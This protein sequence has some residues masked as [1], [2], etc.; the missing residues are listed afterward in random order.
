MCRVGT[1]RNTLGYLNG[2]IPFSEV[3]GLH[4][5]WLISAVHTV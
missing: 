4:Q 1:L 3:G 2:A 5:I